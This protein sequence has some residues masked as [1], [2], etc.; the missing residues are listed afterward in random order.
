MHSS[1]ILLQCFV[2]LCPKTHV[3]SKN[4]AKTV[5]LFRFVLRTMDSNLSFACV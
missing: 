4:S 1:I 5:V 3:A 2:I